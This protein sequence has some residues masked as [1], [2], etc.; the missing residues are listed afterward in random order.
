MIHVPP[1][2]AGIAEA[3]AALRRG[4]VVA[5]PTE[6]VYGLAVDPWNEPALER[7]YHVKGRPAHNPVLLAVADDAQLQ[8]VVATVPA[9]ARPY[10]AAFWPGALTLLFPRHPELPQAVTA[11]ASKVAVRCPA[12]EV[13]R[14]LCRAFGGAVTS[15]SANHAGMPPART[16]AAL[17]QLQ[18]VSVVIDAGPL[19]ECALSTLFDPETG[20]ILRAGAISAAELARVWAPD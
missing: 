17:A 20:E 18:G 5:Y 16:P 13:V 7:L 12:H 4:H 8:A 14:Q 10:M 19:P 15:T 6:T 1:V 2:P 3:V 11:G 9:A